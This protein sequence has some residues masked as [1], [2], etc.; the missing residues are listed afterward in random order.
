MWTMEQLPTAE[1]ERKTDEFFLFYC[2]KRSIH[3]TSKEQGMTDIVNLLEFCYY[4]ILFYV[5]LKSHIGYD[6]LVN[7]KKAI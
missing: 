7:E 4:H 3:V 1:Y 5:L 6:S 2:G